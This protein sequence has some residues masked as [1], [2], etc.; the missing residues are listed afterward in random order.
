M[1]E[2]LA[3]IAAADAI[4][5]LTQFVV[6]VISRLRE[7]ATT[8]TELPHSLKDVKAPLGL[9]RESLKQLSRQSN[10][11]TTQSNETLQEAVTGCRKQ[12]EKLDKILKAVSSSTTDSKLKR[13]KKALVSVKQDREVRQICVDIQ[14]YV[15]IF[16]LDQITALTANLRIPDEEQDHQS[17]LPFFIVPF[18]RDLQFIGREET[19]NRIDH[20]LKSQEVVA[21]AGIGG[22]E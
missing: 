9:L 1:A 13:S 12:V 8:V 10:L 3:T 18:S 15:T 5:H 19:I 11:R 14:R 16:S 21:L 17:R 4:L 2:A 20:M 7:Y 6:E 22:I